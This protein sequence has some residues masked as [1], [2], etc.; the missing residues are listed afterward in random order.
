MWTATISL[1]PSMIIRNKGENPMNEN[2]K[3]S[4]KVMNIL[5]GLT[6]RVDQVATIAQPIAIC[7]N[8]LAD[9]RDKLNEPAKTI[10][11]PDK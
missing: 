6:P 9:V 8:T 5:A 4:Q 2:A 11:N 10:E 3:Q 7:I 1:I